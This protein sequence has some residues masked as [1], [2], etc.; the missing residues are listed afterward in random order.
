LRR[1]RFASAWRLLRREGFSSLARVLV[2]R[3][4]APVLGRP[5]R[6]V[7]IRR[8]RQMLRRADP[9]LTPVV[10]FSTVDYLFPYRQ[11]PQHLALAFAQAG[12]VVVYVSPRSG[13]DNFLV[14]GFPAERVCVTD[15]DDLLP[16]LLGKRAI[17][18]LMS[19]DNRID[20][21]FVARAKQWGA[22]IV[23]DYIDRIDAAIS[24]M[25]IPPGHLS[26]HAAL[27]R[28]PRV[29]VVASARL[30]F[31]EVASLRGSGLVLAQNGV[32]PLH[33]RASRQPSGLM[34]EMADVVRRGRPIAGYF[35]VL[36]S[37]FDYGL[38]LDLARARPELSVVL[39]GP[40]Y[41]GSC[42][43]WRHQA[44]ELP[45]NLF[46]LPPVPYSRLPQHAV[47]FDVGMI[48]FLLNDIT[49]ATSPLKLYEYFAMGIP[50]VAV[51]LPE[52]ERHQ[53]AVL[54]AG[55]ATE[56]IAAIDQAL[57]VRDDPGHQSLIKRE[58]AS[59]AWGARVEA[60]T[61]GLRSLEHA[62]GLD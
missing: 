32:D 37:W 46:L 21:A 36:A 22:R 1:K 62:S 43:S 41:D 44:G 39:I 29:L 49:L 52:C 31:D 7:R 40:D 48:P 57:A 11:R 42:R 23:Y 27:L 54:L 17:L 35:G 9:T 30:L 61:A 55:D 3:F 45:A 18:L 8:L 33:Y 56:F 60:I 20:A 24:L 6:R 34:P 59:N 16:E 15:A 51:R 26:A 58:A 13:H 2:N 28:D 47:W 4:V 50:V 5:F 12:H 14:C 53:P 38:V 10:I 19:T 25:D